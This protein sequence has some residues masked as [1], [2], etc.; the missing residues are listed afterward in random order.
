MAESESVPD[1]YVDQV[2]INTSPF[3][4]TINFMLTGSTPPPPGR[5]PSVQR[6][7]DVRMS[8]EHL[9]VMAYIL[10]KQVRQHEESTGVRIE[11]P[12]RLLGETGIAPED[13]ETFWR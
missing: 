5:P 9:K 4:A 6:K 11:I 3:G 2:Q 8:L 1:V 12:T 7:V 10:Q 13:W